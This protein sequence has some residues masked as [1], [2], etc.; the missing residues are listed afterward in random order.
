MIKLEGS[1]VRFRK[2]DPIFFKRVKSQEPKKVDCVTMLL[3]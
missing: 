1:M 2:K 3:G